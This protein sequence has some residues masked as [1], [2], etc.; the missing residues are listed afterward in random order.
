MLNAKIARR[1]YRR[2]RQAD[3]ASFADNVFNRTNNVPAYASVQ[4]SVTNLTPLLTR[5][6]ETLAAARN[7]GVSEVLAKN[8]ARIELMR[9]LDVIADM[10]ETLADGNPQIIVDAGF[11]LQQ[12][13]GQR[14]A[15]ELPPPVILRAQSTGKKGEVRIV[16]DD[17]IPG[18]VR[19]HAIEYSLDRGIGWQNGEYNSRRNFIAKGLP[20][21]SELWIHLKSIGNGDSKSQWSEPVAVAVL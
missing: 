11:S 14:F 12:S 19:T 5:Y 7:R 1:A 3:L 6:K 16:L 18:A 17:L 8:I 15:G 10:V 2:G 13:S 4:S 9:Q 20:H 21:A